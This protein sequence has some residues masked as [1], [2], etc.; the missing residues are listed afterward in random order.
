MWKYRVA[1]KLWPKRSGLLWS[2]HSRNESKCSWNAFL[3]SAIRGFYQNNTKI[4]S[5]FVHFCSFQSFSATSD[6]LLF[7]IHIT[8][9]LTS[10]IL[11]TLKNE[12]SIF[13]DDWDIKQKAYGHDVASCDQ[14]TSLGRERDHLICIE[15]HGNLIKRP[16][17]VPYGHI[18]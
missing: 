1:Q 8:A 5:S 12:S 18:T 17:E 9:Y 13:S 11:V 7:L 6:Q 2:Y 3:S 10:R 4:Y 16:N 15:P 14:T